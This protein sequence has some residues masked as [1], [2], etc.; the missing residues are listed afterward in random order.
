[1]P[2]PDPDP[3]PAPSRDFTVAV[4]VVDAGRVLLHW[5]RKLGRWLP[6]G[7]HIEPGELPDEAAIRE[8]REETGVTPTLWPETGIDIDLPGQPVQLAR[9]A[10]IQLTDISPG[11]QHIDLIYVATA[12][13]APAD[14]PADVGWF[15][16][17][18][19][20]RLGLT[21]EVAAWCAKA[22]RVVAGPA[23]ARAS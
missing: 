12:A 14:L 13:S 11:H 8:V 6:P 22:V 9:P 18:E 2:E 4:L 7:G 10:G 23:G 16:P 20:P 3:A 21:E 1:M 17:D 5:H 15:G 19:W